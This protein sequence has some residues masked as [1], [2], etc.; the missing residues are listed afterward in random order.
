VRTNPAMEQLHVRRAKSK[1]QGANV[2]SHV[3]RV[4]SG[5]PRGIP[6]SRNIHQRPAPT[7]AWTITVTVK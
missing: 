3:L 2:S 4:K 7:T 1:A 6:A 5:T